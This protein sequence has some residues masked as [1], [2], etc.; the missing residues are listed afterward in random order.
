M[1]DGWK[2]NG[3]NCIETVYTVVD[4]YMQNNEYDG[5]FRWGTA[6]DTSVNGGNIEY[7]F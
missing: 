2:T 6:F 4:L 1:S 3:S 7:V 5:V